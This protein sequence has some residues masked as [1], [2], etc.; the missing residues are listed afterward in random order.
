MLYLVL[1]QESEKNSTSEKYQADFESVYKE[2]D[3]LIPKFKALAN[4]Y[5]FHTK[6]V[7]AQW[8]K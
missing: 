6:L 3:Y 2:I 7:L 4:R 5:A 8:A 1:L